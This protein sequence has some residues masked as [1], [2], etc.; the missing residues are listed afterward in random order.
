MLVNVSLIPEEGVNPYAGHPGFTAIECPLRYTVTP[1]LSGSTSMHGFGCYFTAGHC[2]PSDDCGRRRRV[3][4]RELELD[5][6]EP[7]NHGEI[8]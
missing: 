2:L 6:L 3:V 8:K 1:A 7:L 4:D 5:K